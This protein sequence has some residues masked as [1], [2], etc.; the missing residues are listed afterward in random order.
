MVS[1]RPL[2]S[3]SSSPCTNPLVTVPR[4]SITIGITVTLMFHIFSLVSTSYLSF[5]SFSFS[6]SMRSAGIAKS[7][8]RQVLFFLLII[9]GLVVWLRFGDLFV[10][11][12]LLSL[13]SLLL[14]RFFIFILKGFFFLLKSEWQ[15]VLRSLRVFNL[16]LRALW[17][18]WYRSFPW[19]PVS[20]PKSLFQAFAFHYYW[21][22]RHF[23]SSTAFSAL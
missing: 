23:L 5:F 20:H 16:I 19:F 12:L 11:Q 6:F 3:K 7:T 1:T 21:Y 10:S 2:I 8:I 22:H 14:L 17:S 9:L 15:Q 18:G 13:S 4:A